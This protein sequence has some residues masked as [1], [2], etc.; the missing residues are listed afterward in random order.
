MS[1]ISGAATSFNLVA[2]VMLDFEPF[3]AL[4]DPFDTPLLNGQASNAS[5][6]AHESALSS[7][8]ADETTVQWL[9]ESGLTPRIRTAV[10]STTTEVVVTV[11]SGQQKRFQTDDL[12]VTPAN[13]YVK[14]TGYGT[15][16]DTLLVT[17]GFN[18][19]STATI[20]SGDLLVGVGT[21]T[22]EGADPQAARAKDRTAR[23]NFTQIFGPYKVQV[24]QTE[25]AVKK[26]GLTGNEFSY[27][28]ANRTKEAMVAFEQALIYG[29]KSLTTATAIRTMGGMMSFI[30]TNIDSSTTA[31]TETKLLDQMQNCFDAGGTPN[32]ILVGSK[33]KRVI[34]AFTSAGTV[35][36]FRD[37]LQRGVQVDTFRSDFGLA[38]IMLD[39]WVRTQDLFI[40][41]RDQAKIATLR[42][43][44]FQMLAQTGDAIQGQLVCEKTL[45]FLVESHAARF[46]ALT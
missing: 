30:A 2:G 43:W 4:I 5:G 24:T 41:G 23:S 33:Q 40:F 13:E 31:L 46:S 37:D 21:A 44:T 28:S 36:V 35:Q 19:S 42:P 26:Y 15:T 27:Q 34:S 11:A 45:E 9:D 6:T 12:F 32:R 22:V 20:A 25:L 18:S 38:S 1:G 10:A 39:R 8:G 14:I 7:R 3:I 16:A 29:T 17:R